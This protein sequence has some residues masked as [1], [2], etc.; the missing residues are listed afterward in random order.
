MCRGQIFDKQAGAT[1]LQCG[2]CQKLDIELEMVR[3]TLAWLSTDEL[4]ATFCVMVFCVKSP[5][6]NSISSLKLC[7]DGL[8]ALN[9]REHAPGQPSSH[10][11][12]QIKF[13]HIQSFE[14]ALKKQAVP[15]YFLQLVNNC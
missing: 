10:H 3:A 2:P 15:L 11:F 12:Q 14:N 9:L 8:C 5:S 13:Q 1:A 7:H 6:C 4:T